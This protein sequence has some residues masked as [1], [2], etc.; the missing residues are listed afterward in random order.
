MGVENI[1]LSEILEDLASEVLLAE[2]YTNAVMSNKDA[3]K[4]VNLCYENA[5]KSGQVTT[6]IKSLFSN[7]TKP[8]IWSY[9]EIHKYENREFRLTEKEKN[10]EKEALRC[11]VKN[12]DEK[13]SGIT[14]SVKNEEEKLQNVE[15]AIENIRK[16]KERFEM[17]KKFAETP[18]NYYEDYE[19]AIAKMKKKRLKKFSLTP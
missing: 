19:G 3:I 9:Y 5:R 15:T 2:L 11:K 13:F 18:A 17:E 6:V 10:I 16:V 14:L 7:D 4:K 1:V 12:F 8:K